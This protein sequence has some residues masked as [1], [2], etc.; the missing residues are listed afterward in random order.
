MERRRFLAGGHVLCLQRARLAVRKRRLETPGSACLH[1]DAGG[2]SL[3]EEAAPLGAAPVLGLHLSRVSYVATANSIDPCP[4]R[5]LHFAF[6]L[7]ACNGP[8]NQV[9]SEIA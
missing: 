8:T 1:R 7:A 9:S 5:S 6:G 4:R 3:T 2:T